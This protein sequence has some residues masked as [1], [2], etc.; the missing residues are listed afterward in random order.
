MKKLA[1]A[2]ALALTGSVFGQIIPPGYESSDLKGKDRPP[3]G[4]RQVSEDFGVTFCYY[5]EDEILHPALIE[6]VY[7]EAKKVVTDLGYYFSA[8]DVDLSLYN[9]E[10]SGAG[11][12]TTATT[13]LGEGHYVS[14]AWFIKDNQGNK[15]RA[16]LKL[17]K[18]ALT[19]QII[20]WVDEGYNYE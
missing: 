7:N 5:S 1:L 19:F 10:E 14:R 16:E 12:I 17:F 11:S 13:I 20:D 9:I 8:P 6:E 15:Y 4:L 18:E 3:S 2:L